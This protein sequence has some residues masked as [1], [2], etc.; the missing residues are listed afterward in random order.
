MLKI[1]GICLATAGLGLNSGHA[2]AQATPAKGCFVAHFKSL[3]LKTH[4]PEQRTA[5]AEKGPTEERALIP[6]VHWI[7]AAVAQA[8]RPVV[9][10]VVINGRHDVGTAT[11]VLIPLLHAQF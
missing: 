10:C 11:D 4:S 2:L 3:A 7:A 8:G 9:L 1:I 5:L 6:A